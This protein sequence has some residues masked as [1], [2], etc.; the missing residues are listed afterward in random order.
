MRSI[1]IRSARSLVQ[2]RTGGVTFSAIVSKKEVGFEAN[3]QLWLL[4]AFGLCLWSSGTVHAA[5]A[6]TWWPHWH[7]ISFIPRPAYPAQLRDQGSDQKWQLIS[8]V[9]WWW[10]RWEWKERGKKKKGAYL[11][12]LKKK[13]KKKH[14]GCFMTAPLALSVTFRGRVSLCY[15][16]PLPGN[17]HKLHFPCPPE[18]RELSGRSGRIAT[19]IIFFFSF[20]RLIF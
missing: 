5:T 4:N 3:G 7:R 14:D 17:Y 11:G 9:I 15:R 6:I 12:A 20:H 19:F 13:K 8:S 10:N 2:T 16:P 18:P 1:T